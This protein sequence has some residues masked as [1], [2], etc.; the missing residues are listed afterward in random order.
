MLTMRE[1]LKMRSSVTESYLKRA[2]KERNSGGEKYSSSKLDDYKTGLEQPS[3]N[4]T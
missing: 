2:D 1:V 4:F 3:K